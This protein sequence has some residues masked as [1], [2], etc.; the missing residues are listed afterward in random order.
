V[1]WL[2]AVSL[3][4]HDSAVLPKDAAAADVSCKA[5]VRAWPARGV[6]PEEL[7]A[8]LRR[9]AAASEGAKHRPQGISCSS[10]ARRCCRTLLG[11]LLLR[12]LL[13]GIRV[14]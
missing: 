4:A 11:L 2:S 5:C 7:R 10:E 13:P 9:L 12:A 1:A 14:R 6:D 8:R 3:S